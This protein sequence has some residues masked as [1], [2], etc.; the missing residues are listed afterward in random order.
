MSMANKFSKRLVQVD[1]A[2][3]TRVFFI[4]GIIIALV[5]SYLWFTRLYLTDE[6]RFWIAIENSMSLPSVTRELQSGGSGN[7]VVQSQQFFFSPNQVVASRVTFD[8]ISATESTS[9]I[10]EG[11]SFLDT[12]YSRYTEFSTNQRTQ[13]GAAV[14]IDS[15]LGKWEENAVPQEALE[16]ARQAYVSELVTLVI[17]GNFDSEYKRSVLERMQQE[18]VYEIN[19]NSINHDE[20]EGEDS[21]IYNVS[22]KIKPFVELLNDSFEYAGL[23][24]FPPLDPSGYSDDA[25]P[26][27]AQIIV[28]KRQNTITGV[29]FGTRQERYSGHGIIKDVNRP[30][31]EFQSGELEDA[32]QQQL[33]GVL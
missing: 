5:G 32:V 2:R 4:L 33:Q 29:S 7:Q 15:L 1:I 25:P 21:L 27:P 8:Q 20:F 12:Q 19:P 11:L 31:A 17:F 6:R 23:G 10:T 16:Q 9:V 18:G 14:D 30:T 22:V 26:L 13:D 24:D 3:L 28:N